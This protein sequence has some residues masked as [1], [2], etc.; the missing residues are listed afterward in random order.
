MD[1]KTQYGRPIFSGFMQLVNL[2]A[3]A[4]L[5]PKGTT[6]IIDEPERNLHISFQQTLIEDLMT[7]PSIGK[8]VM[9]T[10]APSIPNAQTTWVPI[11]ECLKTIEAAV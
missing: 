3:Q 11:K 10:H 5:A 1:F 9:A 2:F 6:L 7:I 8:I 4:Y